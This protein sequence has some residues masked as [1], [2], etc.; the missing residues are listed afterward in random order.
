MEESELIALEK[1]CVVVDD[2]L[3]ELLHSGRCGDGKST[4]GY[5]ADQF[6]VAVLGHTDAGQGAAGNL[7]GCE[8][9]AAV[10]LHPLG[11]IDLDD[12]EVG[13]DEGVV[14]RHVLWQFLEATAQH[15]VEL[16]VDGAEVGP[17][18]ADVHLALCAQRSDGLDGSF[19]D[20]SAHL[21]LTVDI[22]TYLATNL[23]VDSENF[24]HCVLLFNVIHFVCSSS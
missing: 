8:D 4:E 21:G 11:D 20:D 16:L 24:C 14:D 13:L 15:R 10:E 18:G 12:P 23:S 22:L 17:L 9:G 2:S 3:R 5:A 1:R 7:I 19:A 6:V